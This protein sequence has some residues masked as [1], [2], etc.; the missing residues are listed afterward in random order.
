M[1][2]RYVTTGGACFYCN[3]AVDASEYCYGCQ[4]YV[5]H[6]CEAPQILFDFISGKDHPKENH[7]LRVIQ[8]PPKE[9]TEQANDTGLMQRR[10]MAP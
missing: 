6:N 7:L 3:Q 1:K 4:N 2:R 8:L 9:I 5:C 10:S